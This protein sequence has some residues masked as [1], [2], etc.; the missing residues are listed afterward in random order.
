MEERNGAEQEILEQESKETEQEELNQEE[1]AKES[2]P[3]FALRQEAEENYNRYLRVQ[4][5]FDN[6]RKRTRKEK[7]ELLK[8]ASLPVIE[9]LLP[10]LDN[11]ER[12]LS[13]GQNAEHSDSLVKGVEM[14]LRQIQQV[15]EQE[16]LQAIEAEGKPFDPQYHQAVMQEESADHEAGIVI[17][18]LQKGYILKDRVVRPAMVKVSS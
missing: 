16:G 13:A 14:V 3:L 11:L 2:D 8:Y 4:A 1:A 18:E 7:E 9:S 15:L 5:D 17:Q 10:A 6:F 12:A